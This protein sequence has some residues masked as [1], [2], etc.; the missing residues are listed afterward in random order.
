MSTHIGRWGN[1]L[2]VRL[3]HAT[4]ETAGL[5]EGTRVKL[6]AA[7][8]R[9]TLVAES[10]PRYTLR[11]LLRGYTRRRRHPESDWGKPRGGEV[12]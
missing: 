7:R 2:A 4:A 11:E 6:E 1:S 3:P 10:L 8:G 12:W 9:V 5:R